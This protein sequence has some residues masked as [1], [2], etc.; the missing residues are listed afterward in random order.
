MGSGSSATRTGTEPRPSMVIQQQ[1]VDLSKV[2]KEAERYSEKDF[3][4]RVGLDSLRLHRQELEDELRAAELLESAS[5]VM[6]STENKITLS[7]TLVGGNIERGRFELRAV[8]EL[9][10]GSVSAA[11]K[12]QL[13][14]IPLG[15]AV[16]AE[17]RVV[18]RGTDD[19]Q[20]SPQSDYILVTIVVAPPE[21]PT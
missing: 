4:S 14:S 16:Q 21:V 13:M 10:H 3:A 6:P 12:E 1:L 9:I 15:S 17:V 8:E 19:E 5:E 20:G 11:A 7:G 2:M 18:V